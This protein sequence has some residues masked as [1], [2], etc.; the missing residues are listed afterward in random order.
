MLDKSTVAY[1]PLHRD[2]AMVTGL[3][4]KKIGMTRIFTDDGRWIEVT[5]VEAG[6]CTVVQRKTEER[7]R[8]YA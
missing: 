3:L 6:P 7:D 4:G 5:V 2:L 8:T 1:G